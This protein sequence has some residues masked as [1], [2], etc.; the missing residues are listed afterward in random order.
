MTVIDP[1]MTL[2]K[3]VV[4]CNILFLHS[5]VW[6]CLL[7]FSTCKIYAIRMSFILF[8]VLF[9]LFLF[10]PSFAHILQSIET[11]NH[12]LRNY[13]PA[14][15]KYFFLKKISINLFHIWNKINKHL[16]EENVIF[17]VYLF[18]FFFHFNLNSTK[19]KN[20]FI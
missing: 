13:N 15:Q 20:W 11:L 7:F 4:E 10:V 19:K 16:C 17:V 6:I 2:D 18:V 8:C 1:F 12:T 3:I 5:N 9:L 14:K